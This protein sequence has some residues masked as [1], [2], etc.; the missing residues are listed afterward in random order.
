MKRLGECLSERWF[1][2]VAPTVT[3]LVFLAAW[4]AVVRIDPASLDQLPHPTIAP[5]APRDVTATGVPASP[6]GASRQTAF[7][8]DEAAALA[9]EGRKVILVR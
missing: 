5:Y 1:R 3:G 2:I 4:E 7:R 8:A 9:A 6:G